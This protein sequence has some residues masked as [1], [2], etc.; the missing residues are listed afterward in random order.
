MN[1]ELI[2]SPNWYRAATLT[3][4]L[5]YLTS[6]SKGKLH[7]DIDMKK[8]LQR[9]K[10]WHSDPPFATSTSF[11]DR[12]ASEGIT[13]EHFL[14]FLGEPIEAV[15]ERFFEPPLWLTSLKQALARPVSTTSVPL[16]QTLPAGDLLRF[17]NVVQPF[18]EQGRD[19]LRDGIIAIQRKFAHLPF[20]PGT[21]ETLLLPCLLR[22]LGSMVTRTMA[23]EL[24]VARLQG[25]LQGDK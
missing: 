4:R 11:A 21:V 13:E 12:L 6:E 15:K 10:R 19:G 24:N 23:L 14:H 7:A 2:E 17:L 16:S 5:A 25:V 22:E 3:E 20:N 18:I 1:Q 9:Q 8:A